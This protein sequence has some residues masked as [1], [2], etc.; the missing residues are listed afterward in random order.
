MS[1]PFI[2][3][4]LH[5][6]SKGIQCID[7][8]NN[9]KGFV[10]SNNIGTLNGTSVDLTSIDLS[11]MSIRGTLSDSLIAFAGGTHGGS[12]LNLEGN[13]LSGVLSVAAVRFIAVSRNK[14]H[15]VILRG[16]IGL[17]LPEDMGKLGREL[18]ILDLSDCSLVL[19]IPQSIDQFS[20]G[21][22]VN[23]SNNRL[24]GELP[25]GIVRLA[26]TMQS[27]NLLDSLAGL[28]N[29]F[30]FNYAEKKVML[31]NNIGEALI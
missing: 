14:G 24:S 15:Q 13:L 8:T 21:T 20:Q 10:L 5:A 28:C 3:M 1:V 31:E 27:T 18:H 6:R 29:S 23:L 11:K 26:S 17:S 16:N 30:S 4:V 2:S 7:I 19:S 25:R 9:P 22:V 12:N